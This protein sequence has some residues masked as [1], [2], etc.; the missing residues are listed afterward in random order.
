MFRFVGAI[1]FDTFGFLDSVWKS[2]MSSFSAVFTLGNSGIHVGT[3]DSGYVTS[4]IKA[5]VNQSF[6]SF[7]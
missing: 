1:I 5:P 7:T 6:E 4:D 2:S 3:S